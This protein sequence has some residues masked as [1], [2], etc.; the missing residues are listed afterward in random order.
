MHNGG[1]ALFAATPL[2]AAMGATALGHTS[3]Q[4]RADAASDPPR[5]ALAQS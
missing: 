4:S 3:D 2:S 1:C 5:T